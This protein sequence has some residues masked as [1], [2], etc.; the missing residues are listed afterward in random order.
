MLYR[1]RKSE[2]RHFGAI[3]AHY[4][5]GSY[6]EEKT[7]TE[8]LPVIEVKPPEFDTTA[9]IESLYYG[10]IDSKFEGRFG[11]QTTNMI[12]DFCTRLADSTLVDEK[13]KEFL[14][15]IKE[16]AN[17]KP[18]NRLTKEM[19]FEQA[20]KFVNFLRDYVDKNTVPDPEDI[21]EK[22]RKCI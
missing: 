7:K 6:R 14:K 15:S 9:F 22:Y 3:A 11:T 4:K 18:L 5:R 12:L 8:T 1:V 19:T 13:K 17:G 2:R 16:A 21:I 20:E 10:I